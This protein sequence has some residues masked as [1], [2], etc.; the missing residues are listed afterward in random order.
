MKMES[1]YASFKFHSLPAVMLCVSL[2]ALLLLISCGGGNTPAA[3]AMM[4][5]TIIPDAVTVPQGGAQTFFA[6][7]QGTGNTAVTWTVQEGAAG[8][9][10][11]SSGMYTAASTSG[12]YHVRATSQADNTTYATAIVTVP[13]VSI[14]ISPATASVNPGATKL[15]TANVEGTVNTAVTWTVQEGTAGGAIA[16][17]GFYTAP[18]ILGTFHVVVTSS[19]DTSKS[20]TALVVVSQSPGNFTP[21]ASMLQVTGVHTATLL[22]D[23]K[24][25][26]AGGSEGTFNYAYGGFPYAELYDPVARSFTTTGSMTSARTFHTASLL[27]N[28]K[29]LVSGGFDEGHPDQPLPESSAELYDPATGSFTPAGTMGTARADHTATL[30]PN[31]K[32]LIAGGAAHQIVD[33]GFPFFGSGFA[34]S[35]VY[36]PAT[37]SFTRTGAMS[38]ARFAHTATLLPNGKVLIAG[39]LPSDSAGALLTAE[40]YDPATGT[41]IAT[42]NM[43]TPRGAHTATLLAN[44]KVLVSGGL[45]S[46][47]ATATAPSAEL[48]DPATGN[49]TPTGSMTE[50]RERHTAT[51]LPDGRVLI[52]GGNSVTDTLTSAEIYDPLTG[53]FAVPGSMGT[54]RSTHTATLLPDGT[55]LVAGGNYK[56]RPGLGDYS[57]PTG[58]AEVYHQ[59]KSDPDEKNGAT[60]LNTLALPSGKEGRRMSACTLIRTLLAALLSAGLSGAG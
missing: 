11:T 46:V 34:E 39:G 50:A 56:E 17:N 4:S 28:G 9:T 47:D 35:E 20:A 12:N 38:A 44:G 49:F 26:V 2:A 51:L 32:V 7:V 60:E 45:M 31:G 58:T 52:V 1:R 53:S 21:T 24:V 13:P 22:P 29:V 43:G 33:G 37:N 14:S 36:D 54:P 59:Q 15:F 41:F 5:L 6:K 55:V 40:L 10:I 18:T 3:Q 19:A 27:P 16:A 25:L 30:L 42:G 48:Y 23:G 57:L 8:G